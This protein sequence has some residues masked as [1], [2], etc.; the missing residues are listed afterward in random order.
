MED[1]GAID[2]LRRS[3][4]LVRG[5][6]WPVVGAILLGSLLASLLQGVLVAPVLVLQL[7]GTSFLVTSLLTGVVQLIGVALTTPYVAALTAVVY[8]DL[9]V[10]KEAFDLELLAGGVGVDPADRSAPTVAA[11]LLVRRRRRPTRGWGHPSLPPAGGGRRPVGPPGPTGPDPVA[12]ADRA[13]DEARRILD[14]DRYQARD[15][16]RPLEGVLRWLG[17]RLRTWPSRSRDLLTTPAGI[18]VALATALALAVVAAWPAALRTPQPDRGRARPPAAG[19]AGAPTRPSSRREADAAEGAG[20]STAPSGSASAPASSA[21]RRSG[22]CP[23]GPTLTSRRLVAAVPPAAGPGPHLRRGRLRRPGGAAG[24]RR[25]GPHGSGPRWWPGPSGDGRPPGERGPMTGSEPPTRPTP[26]AST[27]AAPPRP[28]SGSAW[29]PGGAGEAGGDRP[30]RPPAGPERGD[31]RPRPRR[32]RRSGRAHA[33]RASRPA[34]TASPPGPTC[35]RYPGRRRLPVRTPLEDADLDPC[36]STLV[37]MDPPPTR[38][39]P[40]T[41]AAVAAHVEA[42]GRLVAVGGRPPTCVAAIVGRDP[43]GPPPAPPGPRPSRRG[44]VDGGVDVL[45][46]DGRGSYLTA[47]GLRAPGGGGRRGG[48]RGAGPVVAV[49]DPT[50]L[51][52]RYLAEADDAAF[53]LAL[54][55]DGPVAFAEAEHGYGESQG[56]TALPSSWIQAGGALVVAALLGMWCAGQRLGPPEQTDRPLPPPRTAYLDA[57]VAALSRTPTQGRSL[58]ESEDL[59]R[60]PRPSGGRHVR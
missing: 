10:R 42:G 28:V 58:A 33:A 20:T 44:P 50:L 21:S 27:S 41:V 4:E 36:R 31:R 34:P 47:G 52:N 2:S 6:F 23:P 39:D 22:P 59:D 25:G 57:M 19:A 13:R 37:V 30:R 38:P 54:A 40:A 12:D 11:D 43:G 7:T 53:A 26:S 29:S 35:W 16:P 17:D 1:R 46:G 48:G 55:G 9:R 14:G 15:V 8:V 3:T 49:A 24:R 32:G 18:V 51:W 5:R 45:S 60:S 56:L